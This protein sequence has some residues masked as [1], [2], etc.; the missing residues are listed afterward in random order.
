MVSE[1]KDSDALGVRPIYNSERKIVQK[2]SPS[3]LRRRRT[4]LR[5]GKGTSRRLLYSRSETS[6]KL[7]LFIVVVDYFG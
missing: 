6:A 1:R 2:D 5:I 4:C 3:V 7:G